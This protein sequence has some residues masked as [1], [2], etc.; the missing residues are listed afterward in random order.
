MA[1]CSSVWNT[2]SR[3]RPALSACSPPSDRHETAIAAP[4][5]T[6]I[7]TELDKA[8]H[9]SQIPNHISFLEGSMRPVVSIVVLAA[10][11]MVSVSSGAGVP[12]GMPVV[13]GSSP[14]SFLALPEGRIAYGDTGGAGLLVI[15]V[16]G[17]GDLRGEY[18]YLA[19]L[20]ARAGYRVVTLDLRGMGDSTATWNDYSAHAIGRDV[21]AL[22]DHL[23]A[24]RAVVI[25]TSFAA[26]S[27][28][29]A[30]RDAPEKV[31][32][33]VM[34]SPVLKDYP[35]PFYKKAAV[36]VGFAGPWRIFFW[37]RY[38]D[39]LFPMRKPPDHEAYRAVLAA[40]LRLPGHMDALETMVNL[41]K[42]DTEAIIDQVHKPELIIM[43]TRDRDFDDPAAEAL[44]LSSRTGA[45]LMIAEGAG[46][47]PQVEM[48]EAIAPR[49]LA[50][51]QKLR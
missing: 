1:G 43:G 17:M 23:G 21:L 46:H 24:G 2:L 28:L 29:W 5:A 6:A 42:A 38:W 44:S 51:L 19:P 35:Q 15:A 45:E 16:P 11:S 22:I 34:I 40:D 13:N 4:A 10:L 48:P 33:A 47:Y 18:R 36:A 3:T 32:G 25:G 30:A 50:F 14:A 7:G 26:G 27:A 39:S 41:S 49:I 20:L 31:K 12:V 8:I 9:I 37:T